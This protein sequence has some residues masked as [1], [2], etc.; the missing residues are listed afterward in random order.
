[1][2]GPDHE[3]VTRVMDDLANVLVERGKVADAIA[4]AEDAYTRRMRRET[5]PAD[6]A[7]TELDL[8]MIL[9][10]DPRQRARALELARGAC[11]ALD[12]PDYPMEKK[13]CDEFVARGGVRDSALRD[14]AR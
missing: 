10:A 12:H 1:V 11:A 3:D 4:L 7:A 13:A 8:A 14:L 2:R 6:R 5:E 9:A